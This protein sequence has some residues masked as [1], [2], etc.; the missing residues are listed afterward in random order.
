[1]AQTQ[2]INRRIRSVKNA[3]QITKAME[4]VAASRMRRVGEALNNI[5]VY[6]EMA[7]AIM[8]RIVPSQ[9]AQQHPYFKPVSAKTKL[10][11]IFTSDRGLAGAFNSNVINTALRCFK[12]DRS[13]GISPSVIVFG[14]K[15][16]RFF[17][18]LTNIQ[19]V[20]EYQDIADGLNAAIFAPVLEYVHKNIMDKQLGG[21]TLIY[22]GF[23][24]TLSQ[25]IRQIDLLPISL[26]EEGSEV[27]NEEVYELEPSV[28]DVLE[29]SLRLYLEAQLARAH[30][31]SSASEYAMRMMAMGNATRNAD[32]LLG[33]LTLELNASRQAAITQELAEITAGAEAM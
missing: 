21:V 23:I 14:R 9:E 10:Y 15:G 29:E 16:A 13:N 30:I 31:E 28:D 1:V 4:V 3:K 12:E 7:I 22:T 6:S 26:P 27:K 2:Q 32:E 19:L 17:S 20:G 25:Q 11:I 33:D 18:R 5:R 24:S 8:R